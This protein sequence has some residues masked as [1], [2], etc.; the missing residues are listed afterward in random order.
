MA[1]LVI[2]NGFVLTMDGAGT[3]HAPGWVWVDGDRVAAMGAGSPPEDLA[4][5]A[6][7]VIDATH[8]AVLPGLVNGHTHLSQTFV[9][10]LADDKPLLAW[11]KKVMW[12]IQAAITPQDMRLASLLGLVENLRCGVTAVVQHHKITQSPAHVDAAA[13]A[14]EA[15]GLRML[16]VRGW[17]DLGDAGEPPNAVVEAVTQLRERWHGA[18]DGRIT[19]GFGPLAPWR[20]SDETMRRTVAL[21]RRWGLP[22]HLH[23]AE[24]QDEINMLRQRTGLRHV[25]WL[26]SLDTLGPDVHLVHSVW[27]NDAELDLIARSGA[28][29]VHCPVS[30]MYL[31]SGI[32][33]VRKML[34]RGIS[35]ALATDG[36]GSENS[37]DMIESLKVAA[38]LAKV[39]TGD[40]NA[41]L[42][43]DVLRMATVAGACLFGRDDL[44]QIAPQATADLTLV[45]L[46]NARCMPVHRADSALVFNAA[47]PDVHTVIVGGRI[48]LDAGRV[49]LLD[50]TALLE[51]CRLAARN[52]LRRAGIEI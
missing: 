20:C 49:V 24:A 51:E 5:Q 35:V 41:L 13:E 48:L 18:A 1:N 43:L 17:V 21:A 27:V 25:E 34:D 22:T 29:V 23:V 2:Q 19:V 40:A 3:I 32:A 37:Q 6:E 50:E 14:A 28:L 12:P 15:V 9:R 47:G 33:P 8:M 26:H 11:L 46:D 16:L 30:N 38:L 39:S 10:G 4:V 31:A 36:P 52:L 44:G 45:N 42:P 7:R